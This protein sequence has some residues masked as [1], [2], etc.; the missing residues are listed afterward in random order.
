MTRQNT[1]SLFKAITYAGVY[2]GLLMPL[3]FIPYV[4]FP[5]VF[6]KL[7][8]F[9]VLIGLTFPAY[10]ALAWMEPKYRPPRSMVYGAIAA[11]FIALVFSVVFSTDLLRSWWGNQE[12]MNGLFTLLHF[13]AW[14]TMA[15]GL[16]KTWT[17][18]KRLLNYEV[19]LSV[20]MASVS[21]LQQFNKNLLLFPAGDRIGGLLDNPIYM[22]AYQMFNLTFLALLF[23]RT[24]HP[25]AR[26]LY[27]VAAMAAIVAFAL[28]QSRG[29]LVGLAAV[30][31]TFALY[32][33][34]FTG[35]KKARWGILASAG[36]LFLAYGALFLLRTSEFV[37]QSN[38]LNRLTNFSGASQTRL[39]AWEIAW[40]GFLERP[41]TG[42][43][44]DAF[45]ILF[46]LK[47]NPRSL[48]FGVYETWF[49]RAHNT[50]LDVLSMTGIFGFITFV[51][52]FVTLFVS[53]WRARKAG[54][55]DLPTAAV[56]TALPV[57]YFLQNLFV[58]DHPA[59][60]SMSY[61]LFAFAIAATQPGFMGGVKHDPSIKA[62]A[63]AAVP[64]TRSVPWA[65][66]VIVQLVLLL[67]VWRFSVLPFQASLLVIQANQVRARDIPGAFELMKQAGAISTPYRDEQTF[68]L[69]RDLIGYATNG[70]FAQ[71]PNA[72]EMYDYTTNISDEYIAD[73]PRNTHAHFI[74]AR[75]L[76]EV[77]AILPRE[78]QPAQLGHAEQEYR[79]AIETS[80]QRQQ[81][82]YS[83][84]RLY[85]MVGQ[86]QVAYD[87][88]QVARDANPNVGES[89]W[90]MGITMWHQLNKPEEGKDLIV[91]AM[92]TKTPYALQSVREFLTAAQAAADAGRADV[93]QKILPNLP[94]LGGGSVDLYISIARLYE[95]AGLIE[96]RNALVN[97]V[98]QADPN[99]A[100]QF[101]ALR[102]GSATSID[103]SIG[104]LPALAPAVP[105]DAVTEDTSMAETLS[106]S[107]TGQG[108]RR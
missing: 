29:A 14:L 23:I 32:Y 95:R 101:E 24:K 68:M 76:H 54:W 80:P 43:G 66:L 62:D 78:D 56:L 104:A 36:S 77:G 61:L 25:V 49:D 105:A 72:R 83:L 11:Y 85:S 48:E 45:H 57:G 108:P 79:A 87:T 21:I 7:I 20:V 69:S 52:I 59:A 9:Q 96:E 19:M 89:W 41:L 71:V 22:G 38:I 31:G 98:Q 26:A 5:F 4:I 107:T 99:T 90:Y 74:Y 97:A 16:L 30:I 86:Y 18:W 73:H 1:I 46:N 17:D 103:A 60:F 55:V 3:V 50:V 10:L 6:S 93:L 58:F 102:N 15:I 2:G 75:L 8:A 33:A 65:G 40:K 82:Y 51:A 12:R 92:T 27:A 81:L 91:Q 94:N 67:I 44:L 63:H 39:I 34:F 100:S 13:F 53:V 84:A 42:W 70:Q 37:M 106:A 88:L 28:T 47:Y 35:N 64:Q